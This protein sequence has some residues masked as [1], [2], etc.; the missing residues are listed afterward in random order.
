MNLLELEENME[1]FEKIEQ[2]LAQEGEKMNQD[3][4]KISFASFSG[5]LSKSIENIVMEEGYENNDIYDEESDQREENEPDILK[6][7]GVSGSEKGYVVRLSKS[8]LTSIANYQYAEL[9]AIGAA[10]VNNMMKA[11]I[12]AKS[13]TQDYVNGVCLVNQACF[14]RV[15]IN[16]EITTAIRMKIFG[17]PTKLVP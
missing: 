8:I 14:C 2:N 7:R 13:A 6:V 17:I 3:L 16:G 1:K 4:E 10:A 11:F 12:K 5:L 15:R 9:Q